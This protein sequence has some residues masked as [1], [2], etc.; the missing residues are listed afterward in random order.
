M[1]SAQA[2]EPFLKGKLLRADGAPLINAYILV[3]GV[4]E[5]KVLAYTTSNGDG[6]FALSIPDSI[7]TKAQQ[8]EIRHLGF[9]T[10]QVKLEAGRTDYVLTLEEQTIDL[11]DITVKSRPQI[12]RRGDTLSYDVASFAQAMDRSIGEVI[13]RLPGVEVAEDGSIKY[14]GKAISHLYIDG[15]DLLNGRYALGTRVIPKGMVN[16]VEVLQRH[17]PVKVLEGRI[18]SDETALNLV[19]RE[20]ARLKLMGEAKLGAGLPHQ[21][22]SEIN[23]MLFNKRFKML[24][25]LEG[26]NIGRDIF[27]DWKALTKNSAALN[28]SDSW[29]SPGTVS[30]PGLRTDR[31]L[32]NRAGAI[33]TNNF[34]RTKSDLQITLAIRAALDRTEM[35][36][37]GV[38]ELYLPEDTV[39]YSEFQRY[40]NHPFAVQTNLVLES[41]KEKRF[42]RNESQLRFRRDDGEVAMLTNERMLEQQ[43]ADRPLTISN[44]LEFVPTLGR[45]KLLRLKWSLQAELRSEQLGVISPESESAQR[46]GLSYATAFQRLDRPA[47]Q[48]AAE[49]SYLPRSGKIKQA[50]GLGMHQES[51]RLNSYLAMDSVSGS[52]LEGGDVFQNHL[53]W[54]QQRWYAQAQYDYAAGGWLVKLGLPLALQSIRYEDESSDLSGRR[55]YRFLNPTLN[56]RRNIGVEDYLRLSYQRRNRFGTMEQIYQEPILINYRTLQS[57][58]SG[59]QEQRTQQADLSFHLERSL[60][61]LFVYVQL[62]ASH[63]RQNALQ[64]VEITEDGTQ[65]YLVPIMNDIKNAGLEGSWSQYINGLRTTVALRASARFSQLNQLINGDLLPY[66]QRIWTLKPS[67]ERAFGSAVQFSYQALNSFFSSLPVRTEDRQR[68]A[69]QRVYQLDHSLTATSFLRKRIFLSFSASQQL[70][71]EASSGTISYWFLDA[72]ARWRLPARGSELELNL[73]NLANI[74]RYE[75]FRLSENTFW[76]SRYRLQGR[77]AVLKYTF[78]F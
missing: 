10:L 62:S 71:R 11:S 54:N 45:G 49:L 52:A 57:N 19:I 70:T 1:F 4:T 22:D 33:N 66:Q 76:E 43:L 42:I 39:R 44:A 25:V 77:M 20:E 60:R 16:K 78:T 18:A 12:D 34:F 31:Y 55:V 48:Q 7:R 24:H 46:G 73:K 40:R 41:N 58:R 68:I 75:T 51:Q 17:Q 8:L 29:I 28:V 5:G 65:S 6:R 63:N 72:S 38:Q 23:S 47:W 36:F 27:S 15:D 21:Y 3:Q 67:V 35:E 69:T 59:I 64:A 37:S 14:N 26:N 30:P 56:V 61:F 9:R 50:Y 2:Q 13:R 53:R 74:R 32:F